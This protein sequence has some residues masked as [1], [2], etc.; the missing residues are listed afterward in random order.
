MW[1]IL[2][3]KEC[4]GE[5]ARQVHRCHSTIK[6]SNKVQTS[7]ISKKQDSVRKLVKKKKPHSQFFFW[8]DETLKKA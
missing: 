5:L 6:R 2:E 3:K 8:T 4:I 7:D 1:Y